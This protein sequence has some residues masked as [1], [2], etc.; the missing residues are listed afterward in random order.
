MYN[1]I[2]NYIIYMT[3]NKKKQNRIFTKKNN[4]DS[5][6]MITSF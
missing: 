3:I 2:I 4:N 1:N 5:D 6:R